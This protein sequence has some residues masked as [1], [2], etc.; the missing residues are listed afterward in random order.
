M[1]TVE[2]D[3]SLRFLIQFQH[4]LCT[5]SETRTRVFWFGMLGEQNMM[6]CCSSGFCGRLGGGIFFCGIYTR[7]ALC[8][9]FWLATPY[10]VHVPQAAQ[11]KR[12]SWI[13]NWEWSNI[14][15][16]YYLNRNN[17]N[18]VAITTKIPDVLSCTPSHI[19]TTEH[20][21]EMKP[22]ANMRSYKCGAQRPPA[23][24]ANIM[25]HSANFMVCIN[26]FNLIWNPRPKHAPTFH[27][28]SWYC[29]LCCIQ[30]YPDVHS[31]PTYAYENS[32]SRRWVSIYPANW[33]TAMDYHICA[34]KDH[35]Y[36]GVL[37]DRWPMLCK[38]LPY[39]IDHH[40]THS[41]LLF[42]FCT[43]SR[44]VEMLELNCSK[45]K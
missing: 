33:A 6:R 16:E 29:T 27:Y 32:Q 45:C 30:I 28:T 1:C 40:A 34:A 39:V 21:L 31:E 5:L 36:V 12:G 20:S 42:C 10:T 35:I 9:V 22:C 11:P 41:T 17:G 3:L 19:E 2:S 44:D 14:K 23:I 7:F 18:T 8:T 15:L 37:G 43:H 4:E 24:L 38:I 25:D 26:S 13:L